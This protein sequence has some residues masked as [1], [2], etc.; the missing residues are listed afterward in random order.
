MKAALFSNPLSRYNR[1][2]AGLVSACAKPLGLAEYMLDTEALNNLTLLDEMLDRH[3]QAGGGQKVACCQFTLTQIKVIGPCDFV[4][5]VG[6]NT[7]WLLARA[8]KP[9]LGSLRERAFNTRSEGV[10]TCL[11]DHGTVLPSHEAA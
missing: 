5:R 11:V 7:Y 4:G 3:A 8:R 10:A 2:H 9:C 1:V 6:L